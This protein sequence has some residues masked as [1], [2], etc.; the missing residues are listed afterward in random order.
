MRYPIIAM[1]MTLAA[2]G[3]QAQTKQELVQKVLA[4]QQPAIE[5]IARSLAANTSQQILETA[6]AAMGRVPKDKQESV[7]KTIQDD[8]KKFYD[9]IAPVLTISAA[10]IA[11]ASV[12]TMLDQKFNEEELKQI[13]VWLESPT[14]KKYQQLSGEMQDA[15][16]QKLVADTR[17][18]VEAKLKVLEDSIRGHLEASGAG[19]APSKAA[20][21]K[22]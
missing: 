20:P 21:K 13:A 12:G 18:A 3:V 4:A 8:V 22:K 2:F 17:P 16:T 7:G 19:A 14:A 5:G 11:P 9:D 15:L 10:R 1:A 6:G